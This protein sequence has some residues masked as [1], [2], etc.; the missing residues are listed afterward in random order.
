[1]RSGVRGLICSSFSVQQLNDS[2]IQHYTLHIKQ[3]V[4]ILL[5]LL[6]ALCSQLNSSTIK[7]LND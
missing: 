7:Q 6:F 4:F 1:M 3:F 5:S 2:T